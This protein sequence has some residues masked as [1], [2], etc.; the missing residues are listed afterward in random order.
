[1]KGYLMCSA[2]GFVFGEIAVRKNCPH[3]TVNRKYGKQICV[4]CCKKCKFVK[5]L[6]TGWGCGYIREE[7]K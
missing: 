4:Y 1:M 6:G 7:S 3:P 5:M 2:C